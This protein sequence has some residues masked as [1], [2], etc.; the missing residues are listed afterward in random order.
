MRERENEQLNNTSKRGKQREKTKIDR[1]EKN[2]FLST[3]KNYIRRN[4]YIYEKYI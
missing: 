3:S 1:K 4:I 2:S